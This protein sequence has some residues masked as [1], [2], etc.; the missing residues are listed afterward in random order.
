MSFGLLLSDEWGVRPVEELLHEVDA[1]LYAAKAGGRNCVRVAKPRVEPE[2]PA[3][4]MREP[5]QRSR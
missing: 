2:L 5:V 1:A 3:L 4:A